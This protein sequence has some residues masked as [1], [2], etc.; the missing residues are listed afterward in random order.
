W[1]IG[2]VQDEIKPL[3]R[4]WE[5]KARF[6]GMKRRNELYQYFG[7]AS[8]LVLPSLEEGLAL[9]QAQA[10]A[11]GVPVIASANTGA[12]D[13]FSDGVE[14]YIVPIRDPE[15]IRERILRLYEEPALRA[16]MAAAALERVRSIGGWQ[17]Y[18]EQMLA[19]YQ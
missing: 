3:L 16:T 18:G 19:V 10:M 4:R 17:S 12:S 1:I 7:Q 15:A 8:V 6:L 13:L 14:G 9:V 5:G 2:P 11:C